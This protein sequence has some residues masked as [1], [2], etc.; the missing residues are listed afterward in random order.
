[1]QVAMK[2][3]CRGIYRCVLIDSVQVDKVFNRFHLEGRS[4][5]SANWAGV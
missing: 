1:M 5:D 2:P 4:C 3:I